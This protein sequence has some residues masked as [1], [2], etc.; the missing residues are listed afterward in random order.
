MDKDVIK[1]IIV[2]H[3]DHGKST[4]IGRILF[5]TKSL[6]EGRMAELKEISKELGKE[7]E[8]AYLVDYLKE[9]RENNLTIDTTQ[10]FFKSP[11][12][13]YVIIDAPGHLE[14]IKN[15]LTGAT[16][17]EAA[18]L[19]VDVKDGIKEQTKRHAFILNMLGINKVIVV[20]NK[21]DLVNYHRERFE[22]VKGELLEF[23][24]ILNI[25]PLF[26]IPVSARE[27][28]NVFRHSSAIPWYKGPALIG[29]LD[30]VKLNVRTEEKPLRFPVQDIYEIDGEKIIV[31]RV[32]SGIIS[33]NQE[34]MIMPSLKE[35]GVKSI[36][37]FK[38][39]KK[40]AAS[41]ESIGLKLKNSFLITRGE[42]IVSKE[43]SARSVSG[44]KGNI[45]W[46]GQN[47]LLTGEK[48]LLRCATQEVEVIIQKIEKRI[49]SSTL[50][51]I[52]ENAASLQLNEAGII[53]FK[54]ASPLM[55]ERFSFIEELGRFIIE[56]EGNLAG[57]GIIN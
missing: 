2:G 17:A 34:V 24:K 19:I 1:I 27:G 43:E 21:M 23:L 31:G 40:K 53:L 10:I 25:T 52:E 26:S 3:V 6:P 37:V 18:V 4:L 5:E 20:F 12:R 47:P 16:L 45:F 38:E 56:K 13:N 39:R 28:D 41:G 44:F 35:T 30:L 54:T 22:E 9:E 46:L 36:E 11:R 14:F 49:N 29:A 55:V 48:A 50:E 32:S 57:A 7:T 8:L 15:M 51:V 42:I 33:E